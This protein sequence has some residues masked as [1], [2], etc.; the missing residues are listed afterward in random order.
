MSSVLVVNATF[1]TSFSA[2]LERGALAA[3]TQGGAKATVVSVAG[4]LEIPAVIAMASSPQAKPSF[5]GFV[6]LGVVIRGE[7]SH[8]DIVCNESARGLQELAITRNLAIGNG[9]LTVEDEA[10]ALERADPACGDKGGFA[11]RACLEMIAIRQR[12]WGLS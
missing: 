10:Q 6:A 2:L 9:I 12:L 1:Y 5:D 8:Y 3:L 7:T 4:A 11:A